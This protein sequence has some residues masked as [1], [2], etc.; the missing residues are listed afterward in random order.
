M[1]LMYLSCF[2][3]IAH[4]TLQELN[5]SINRSLPAEALLFAPPIVLKLFYFEVASDGKDLLVQMYF[6]LSNML[7]KATE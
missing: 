7:T 4:F 5:V 6:R 1:W 3:N 2:S